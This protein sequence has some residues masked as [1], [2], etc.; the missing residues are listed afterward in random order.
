MS[1]GNFCN[2]GVKFFLDFTA[3]KGQI[4]ALLVT[5]GSYSHKGGLMGLS[6]G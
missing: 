6:R 3:K 2:P 4:K 5:Q 1:F